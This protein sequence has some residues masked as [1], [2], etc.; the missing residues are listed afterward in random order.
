[1]DLKYTRLVV[2]ENPEYFKTG[3]A[4]PKSGSGAFQAHTLKNLGSYGCSEI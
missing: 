1:M 3:S 4:V 2:H